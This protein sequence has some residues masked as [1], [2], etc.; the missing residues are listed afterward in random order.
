MQKTEKIL[1]ITFALG[2]FFKI[3]HIPGNSVFIVFPL[4][5]LCFLYFSFSF[6]IFNEIRFKSIFQSESYK[7]PPITMI[8]SFL[9][10]LGLS[11]LMAGILYKLMQYNNRNLLLFCGLIISGTAFLWLLFSKKKVNYRNLNVVIT[12]YV[13]SIGLAILLLFIMD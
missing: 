10:G 12:R 4:L 1:W 7:V 6:L 2:M 5:I 13:V 11:I 8:H 3:L 9:S